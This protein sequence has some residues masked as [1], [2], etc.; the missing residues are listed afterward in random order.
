MPLRSVLQSHIENEGFAALFQNASMGILV[1]DEQGEIILANQ[2][3]LGQFGYAAE[4]ELVRNKVEMLI[5]KRYQP[6][7]PSHRDDFVKK[8]HPRPMGQGIDLFAVRKG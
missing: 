6:N 8:P 5:P 2:Y 7:H 4:E 3:L 1:S